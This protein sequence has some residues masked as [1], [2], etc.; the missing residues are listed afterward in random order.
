MVFLLAAVC[1]F[2]GNAGIG[3]GHAAMVEKC[4]TTG[5]GMIADMLTTSDN[6]L[7]V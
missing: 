1:R 4:G 7:C 5:D 3:V 6:C 2:T